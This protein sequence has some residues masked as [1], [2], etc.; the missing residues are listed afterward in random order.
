MAKVVY[1]KGFVTIDG[2]KVRK[3]LS[4]KGLQFTYVERVIGSPEQSISNWTRRG[5][6]DEKYLEQLSF[7]TGLSKEEILVTDAPKTEVKAEEKKETPIPVEEPKEDKLPEVKVEQGGIII[8][9]RDI[10]DILSEQIKTNANIMKQI[11]KDNEELR[12]M[13]KT[14]IDILMAREKVDVVQLGVASMEMLDSQYRFFKRQATEKANDVISK[15]KEYKSTNDVFSTAYKLLRAE[16]GIVWEQEK[17]E[18]VEV[19]GYP[20]ASTL[21]L[22]YWIEANKP[23]YH[24]LF[25]SKLDSLAK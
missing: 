24:K 2:A 20:P 14:T 23:Q 3:A 12:G 16:Y 1:K 19:N 4:N 6:M 8:D 10:T 21:Q 17:K 15:H 18:F 5:R 11:Q 7:L 25:L 13:L 22:C 9:L